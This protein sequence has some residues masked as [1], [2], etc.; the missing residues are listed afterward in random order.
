MKELK[1]IIDEVY[2]AI[3]DNER[4]SDFN[5]GTETIRC[6]L[7]KMQEVIQ[8]LTQEV[9][10][11]AEEKIELIS[12]DWKFEFKSYQI[13]DTGDYDCNYEVYYK[14]DLMFILADE[15]ENE[16]LEKLIS[17]MNE[18][19]FKISFT[20]LEDENYTLRLELDYLKSTQSNAESMREHALGFLEYYCGEKL[21]IDNY[22][23]LYTEYLNT[24]TTK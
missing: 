3:N 1:Q 23:K 13:A 20:S 24:L 16:D 5:I 15:Y 8:S 17:L 10:P 9:S 18:I 21:Q 2:K 14:N 22:D 4:M 12:G 6:Y 7:D 11:N 19:D